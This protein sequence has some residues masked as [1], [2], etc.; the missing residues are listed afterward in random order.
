MMHLKEKYK[1]E[2]VPAMKE[3]FGYKNSLAVP[4]I[5]KVVVNTGIG[6]IVNGKSG[7]EKDKIIETVSNDLT[8]IC[9]QKA[10]RTYAKK[11]IASFSLREGSPVGLKVTL[12]GQKMYDFLERLI[13][14]ALPRSRDFK[15]LELKSVDKNGNLTIGLKEHLYFPEVSP[16]KAKLIFGL[17]I[18]VTTN[19][20][21]K[22]KGTE[23][24]RLLGFPLKS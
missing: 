5:E 16:E 24:L 17:E 9:G 6:K 7:K 19:A 12:R 20:K 10:V 22:E 15:G 14:I 2:V 4:V 11:S 18:A 3:K 13:H 8:T 1:K 21:N 23:L